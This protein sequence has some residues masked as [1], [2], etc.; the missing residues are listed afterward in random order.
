MISLRR[1]NQNLLLNL[2]RLPPQRLDQYEQTNDGHQAGINQTRSLRIWRRALPFPPNHNHQHHLF[3]PN[4]QSYLDEQE[5][6]TNPVELIDVGVSTDKFFQTIGVDKPDSRDG[7]RREASKKTQKLLVSN[8]TDLVKLVNLSKE[9]QSLDYGEMTKAWALSEE[10]K[11]DI[12]N[13]AHHYQIFR[14]LFS[15][16]SQLPAERAPVA[17][18]KIPQMQPPPDLEPVEVLQKWFPGAV[19]LERPKSKKVFFFTPHVPIY[20]EFAVPESRVTENSSKK[21]TSSQDSLITSPVVRGNHILPAYASEKPSVVIDARGSDSEKIEPYFNL[22][23]VNGIKL[24]T[25]SKSASGTMFSLGL[26]NLDTHF[27]DDKPVCHW[28]VSNIK[29]SKNGDQISSEENI[30]FLST[31]GIRGFGYH[32]YA[33]VLYQ[34]D[35]PLT[36]GKID[37]TLLVARQFDPLSVVE[38]DGAVPVGLS[39]FQ[40]T[41]D[42][43]SNKVFHDTLSKSAMHRCYGI[44]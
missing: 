20:V 43:H 31:F 33:F 35:K 10:G 22:I 44:N 12:R 7:K 27:G 2:A 26:F 4:L 1:A 34:H 39:W 8:E 18:A 38:K 36:L 19:P 17:K 25:N 23:D 41:W 32:R 21:E 42:Y 15:S 29:K 14:D 5:A 6:L 9:K 30:P 16:P 24:I 3:L 28:F 11:H 13:L 37:P 40:T